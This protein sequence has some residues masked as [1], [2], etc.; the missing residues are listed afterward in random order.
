MS[1]MIDYV[2]GL[3]CVKC[4]I[5]VVVATGITTGRLSKNNGVTTIIY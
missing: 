3:L 5:Y 2:N 1:W 4:Y